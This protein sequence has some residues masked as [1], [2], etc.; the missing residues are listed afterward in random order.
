MSLLQGT[1][2]QK[3]NDLLYSHFGADKLW[4]TK[5]DVMELLSLFVG[6]LRP[7]KLNQDEAYNIS[8]LLECLT[9]NETV[10]LELI[11]CIKTVFLNK[12]CDKIITEAGILQDSDFI[13]EIR[14]RIVA[15]FLPEQPDKNT[16]QYALNQV[17]YD[18]N[19]GEWLRKIPI[20]QLKQLFQLLEFKP[21]Y[22]SL[23]EHSLFS[24]LLNSLYLIAQRMSGRAME[25]EIMRMV[26]E[27]ENRE[28]PFAALED[29]LQAIMESIKRNPHRA[30]PEQTDLGYKQFWILHNHC[31]AF[32]DKAFQ[33]SQKYGI[34]LKVNQNLLRIKQQLERL[35]LLVPL[36]LANNDREKQEKTIELGLVLIDFNC[37]KNNVRK[38]INESTTLISYEITQHTAKTGEKYISSSRK[39][40]FKML[41]TAFG[42]GFIVGIMC[43]VKVLFSKYEVSDFGHAVLY[44]INYALGFVLIYLMG[45][46]LATKQPAMTAAALVKAL[47]KGQSKDGVDEL[48]YLDFA[49]L[50]ARVFRTQFIAFVGNVVMAFP[51]ALLGIYFIDHYYEYNIAATKWKTL[52]VDLSPVHSMA[53]FHSAIAGVFLFMSGIIAGYVANR[54]KHF[55]IPKRIAEHPKLKRWFGKKF[56]FKLSLIYEKKWPGISSNVWFGVFMGSIVSV[57]IFLGLNLD[58]RHITFAS[59]NLAL[60]AYGSG[61][62]LTFSMVFW[63]VLGIGI[64]GFVNF[65]VSFMLSL[66]L[67]FR[68]RNIP[69]KEL[70]L[71]SLSIWEHFKYAY[72][73][74]F[75]PPKEDK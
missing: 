65:I 63:G 55:Q 41:Y 59:G 37:K 10:R 43:I 28:S 13:Y 57:G 24:E 74:F 9:T 21:L 8:E 12:K 58:I 15:K 26:P 35:K 66:G 30:L 52:V 1:N 38:L 17:F 48:K 45:F 11:E 56:T 62:N 39:E 49:L 23:K 7:S 73:S 47:E 67:A 60:A 20:D 5:E 72:Y 71:V 19:D 16:L 64:I 68:S 53:I 75:F 46:T 2:F 18:K 51:V 70:V 3:A 22:A 50:F 54:D 61:F 44:S 27:Y 31:E 29:E 6:Y 69:F 33:N 4:R 34:T 36:L 40:Y 25:S 42:G 32:V 14:K